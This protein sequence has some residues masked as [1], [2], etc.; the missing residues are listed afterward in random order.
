M[1]KLFG[2]RKPEKIPRECLREYFDE[3]PRACPRCGGRLANERETYLVTD[4]RS[5]YIVG[6]ADI[7]WFCCTCPTAVINMHRVEEMID[8]AGGGP[9]YA[10]IGIIDMDDTTGRPGD[11]ILHDYY[12][13]PLG[14]LV[15]FLYEDKPLGEIE[16]IPK[17]ERTQK[18]PK[19]RRRRK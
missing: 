12:G 19:K 7:G 10:P 3:P 18:K 11:E 15:P 6:G 17:R 4:G 14:K 8:P 9:N 13:E 1:L 5:D 2:R 16:R